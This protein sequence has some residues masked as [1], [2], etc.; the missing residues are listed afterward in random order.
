MRHYRRHE[1]RR[2]WK[3]AI[4]I[5]LPQAAIVLWR[6]AATPRN[7]ASRLPPV[8]S[9]CCCC[10][11]ARMAITSCCHSIR[12]FRRQYCRRHTPFSLLPLRHDVRRYAGIFA[13]QRRRRYSKARDEAPAASTI[14]LSASISWLAAIIAYFQLRHENTRIDVAAVV[15]QLGQ[16]RARGS[17]QAV[18]PA[19]SAAAVC[20]K[21]ASAYDMK[22]V[23]GSRRTFGRWYSRASHYYFAIERIDCFHSR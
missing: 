19:R 2:A 21:E 20:R 11:G 16:Q 10:F 12:S 14:S 22:V 8:A 17:A 1:R 18:A 9:H 13:G 4:V 15:L 6:Y 7:S 23:I 3:A 5:A